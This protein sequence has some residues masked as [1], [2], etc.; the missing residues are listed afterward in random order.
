MISERSFDESSVTLA[1]G[2]IHLE[3]NEEDS[4]EEQEIDEIGVLFGVILV[5]FVLYT[6]TVLTQNFSTI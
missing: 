6:T 5:I 1:L 4:D 3:N 2:E